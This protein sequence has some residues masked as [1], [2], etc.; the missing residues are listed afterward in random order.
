[1]PGIGAF[2]IKDAT[3]HSSRANYQLFDYIV[4]RHTHSKRE[5]L[6]TTGS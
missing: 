4:L 3:S 1:M 5:R 6:S 2:A